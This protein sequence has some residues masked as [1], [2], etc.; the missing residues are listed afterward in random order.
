M[1]LQTPLDYRSFRKSLEIT[2]RR[3]ILAQFCTTGCCATLIGFTAWFK[4]TKA[5]LNLIAT[6]IQTNLQ[7]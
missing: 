5:V 2:S 1:G 7:V 3:T 6:L 4:C